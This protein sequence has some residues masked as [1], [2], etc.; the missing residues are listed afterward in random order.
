MRRAA[1][2]M[3]KKRTPEIIKRELLASILEVFEGKD[4]LKDD[5]S[6]VKKYEGLLKEANRKII[7][8]YSWKTRRV[9]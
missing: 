6:S 5:K 7:Y 9:A 1:R 3:R 4:Y 2:I 8:I